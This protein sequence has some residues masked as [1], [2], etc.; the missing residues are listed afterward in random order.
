MGT[1]WFFWNGALYFIE[2]RKKLVFVFRNEFSFIFIHLIFL[3]DFLV[4]A[5]NFAKAKN[6]LIYKHLTDQETDRNNLINKPKHIGKN[7][8]KSDD[9]GSSKNN[10][11]KSSIANQGIEKLI[12][13]CGHTKVAFGSSGIYM[14]YF[15]DYLFL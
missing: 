11:D 10:G 9:L 3:G 5:T 4:S 13:S 8:K 15:L 12:Y 6:P 7:S 14:Y 1:A 2:P